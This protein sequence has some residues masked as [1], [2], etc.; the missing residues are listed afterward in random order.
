MLLFRFL[1]A[2]WTHKHVCL[3]YFLRGES[4]IIDFLARSA[5]K[6]PMLQCTFAARMYN[7]SMHFRALRA[8]KRAFNAFF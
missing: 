1:R 6:N 7:L 5:R 4:S 8:R 3:T 2:T